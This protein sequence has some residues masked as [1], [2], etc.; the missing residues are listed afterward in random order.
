[1]SNWVCCCEQLKTIFTA[2]LS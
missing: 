2:Q 1:M